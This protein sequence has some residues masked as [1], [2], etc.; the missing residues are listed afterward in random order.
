MNLKVEQLKDWDEVAEE[1]LKHFSG[2]KIF[3]LHGEMGAGKTTL[4]KSFCK[5]LHAS[6]EA[7]SPT[8]SLVNEYHIKPYPKSLS[9]RQRAFRQRV[10]V[11]HDRPLHAIIL[12]S[13][14]LA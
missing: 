3:A 4:V 12:L 2:K 5:A 10:G 13:I 14:R 6:D 7:V 9:R 8:F 1:I 11:G